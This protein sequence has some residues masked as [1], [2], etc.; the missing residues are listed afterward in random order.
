MN[1]ATFKEQVSAINPKELAL[2]FDFDG[3]ITQKY[4]N[5]TEVASIISIL[6]SENILSEAYSE[7]AFELKNTYHPIETNPDITKEVKVQKMQEW[8]EKHTALLLKHKLSKHNVKQAAYHPHLLIRDGIA[9]LFHFAE[10]HNVPV[11]IF[12][13]SGIGDSIE[14]FLERYGILSHNVS[15]ISNRFVYNSEDIA[16]SN[17]PPVIHGLNKHES[18]LAL[19]PEIQNTLLSKPI[20]LVF[21]DSPSD[22]DMVEDKN[23]TKV[24]RIGFCNEKDPA[25]KSKVLPLFREKFDIVIENDGNLDNAYTLIP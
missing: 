24:I 10:E 7:A 4:V 13:A 8:W 12:S 3:T 19:F 11:V 14:F 22:A 9:D 21:G 18:T 1:G 6:R 5:N 20:V 15:I 17:I 25:K 23:H 16:T 2:V